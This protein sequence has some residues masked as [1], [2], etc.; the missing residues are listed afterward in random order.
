MFS[1]P[2]LESPFIK[3]GSV[4]FMPIFSDNL[5]ILWDSGQFNKK[6]LK[7]KH[8]EES[9]HGLGAMAP[10]GNPSNLGG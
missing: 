4:F 1:Y 6:K 3:S 2:F 10:T 8:L 7:I 9:R 5:S